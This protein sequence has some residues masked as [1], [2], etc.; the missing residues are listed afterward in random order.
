MYVLTFG[1]ELN[2]EQIAKVQAVAAKEFDVKPEAVK[3]GHSL[4]YSGPTRKPNGEVDTNNYLHTVIPSFQSGNIVVLYNLTQLFPT[5]FDFKDGNNQW[6]YH[7]FPETKCNFDKSTYKSFKEFHSN[8][9]AL[10]EWR[11]QKDERGNFSHWSKLWDKRGG[12]FGNLNPESLAKEGITKIRPPKLTW[13]NGNYNFIGI[14]NEDLIESGSDLKYN[15][16]LKL[17]WSGTDTQI[18]FVKEVTSKNSGRPYWFVTTF[19][20]CAVAEIMTG[21]GGGSR[22]GNDA[23]LD[24]DIGMGAAPI[25]PDIEELTDAEVVTKLRELRAAGK[26]TDDEYDAAN[27][28]KAKRELLARSV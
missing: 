26:I 12:K 7:G 18:L 10:D 3:H 24:L 2:K 20:Y 17:Q 5:L 4:T 23:E 19:Y 25:K 14:K 15:G 28:P 21:L 11:S 9:K 16:L 8:M 6:L 27:S 22:E 13:A 1:K